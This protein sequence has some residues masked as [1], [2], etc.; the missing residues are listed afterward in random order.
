MGNRPKLLQQ[1]RGRGPSRPW[2]YDARSLSVSR[3]R[4][5]RGIRK[6]E[7]DGRK[8]P[9]RWAYEEPRAPP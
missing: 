9:V 7:T 3:A 4:S 1:P 5:P 6:T 2:T 8:G